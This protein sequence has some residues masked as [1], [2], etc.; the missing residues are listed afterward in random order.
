MN[1]RASH[2]IAASCCAALFLLPA[3]SPVGSHPK[4]EPEPTRSMAT[5]APTGATE[6]DTGDFLHWVQE[7]GTAQQ[8]DAVMVHVREVV[9]KWGAEGSHAYVGTDYT[10]PASGP[11]GRRAQSVAQ[12]FTNWARTRRT[13]GTVDVY[14]ANGL[15]LYGDQG[16]SGGCLADQGAG[17]RFLTR[18][19]C[20]TPGGA[21]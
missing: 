8:K 3:C 10:G 9:G 5:D 13:H 11:D 1:R 16:F 12:V 18:C 2:L 20:R 4:T 15:L 7:E 17:E 14:S 19:S 6:E 21:S